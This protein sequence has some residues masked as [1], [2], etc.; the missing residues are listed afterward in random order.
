MKIIEALSWKSWKQNNQNKKKDKKLNNLVAETEASPELLKQEIAFQACLDDIDPISTGKNAGLYVRFNV[1]TIAQALLV[2]RQ[3]ILNPLQKGID[4]NY[5]PGTINTMMKIAMTEGAAVIIGHDVVTVAV[6]QE[7]KKLRDTNKDVSMVGSQERLGTV[8]TTNSM[9]HNMAKRDIEAHTAVAYD[10]EDHYSWFAM[11]V[12]V[13]AESKEIVD[14]VVTKIRSALLEGGIRCEIPRFGQL[15]TIQ[16]AMPTNVIDPN[17]LQLV[18][19][20]TISSLLPL[21]NMNATFP[22]RGPIICVEAS[23]G[24]PIKIC[25][26]KQ[27][28]ENTFILAPPGSGKTTMIFNLVSHAIGNGDEAWIIEPKNEDADGTDYINFVNAYDGSYARWGPEGIN[29]DPLIIYYNRSRMGTSIA[30][31]RK[32]KDDWFDVVQNEFRAWIGDMGERQSGLLTKSLIDLYIQREIIDGEGNPINTEKWDV[33]GALNWPSIHELRMFWNEQFEKEGTIYYHDPSIKALYM[34]TMNAEPGGSLWWLAKSKEHM[35]ISENGL[36]LFDISQLSDNMKSAVAIQIMG[37]CNSLYFPKPEDIGKRKRTYLIFDEIGKLSKTKEIV[38]YM[39]RSLREGRAPALTAVLATQDPI[40]EAEFLSMVKANCKNL[41]V[42]CNLDPMNIDTFMDAFKITDDYRNGLMQKGVG[43][44][45]YFRNRIGTRVRIELD[46]MVNEALLESK[47]G[48]VPEDP[49][50]RYGFG[51]KEAYRRLL[52]EQGFFVESWI[53]SEPMSTYPGYEYYTPQDPLYTGKLKAWILKDNIEFK[54]GLKADGTPKV[55]LVGPEGID[56]F[57]SECFICGWMRNNYFPNPEV[58]PVGL[59]DITWGEKDKDGNLIDP[60]HS[61]CIEI[62]I[63]GTHNSPSVWEDKLKRAKKMGYKHIIFTGNSTVC[64]KMQDTVI[65]AY[66]QPQGK[67][68]LL[69]ELER[70]RD[71]NIRELL[72]KSQQTPV[73]F[74]SDSGMMEA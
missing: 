36:Q 57:S 37:M 38:P 20:W 26:T 15:A 50:K 22:S 74:G 40:L 43:I 9:Y 4:I 73:E 19:Q 55:D 66:V 51:V 23:T 53:T 69:A 25:P 67:I 2:A 54:E 35:K 28:P 39:E 46:G 56:H 48:K 41:F 6:D 58:N 45:Y 13:L 31:Y 32:A 47:R 42:L 70:I 72:T 7:A 21:R 5:M 34:N 16:A 59:P 10:G 52:E 33:P 63:P 12:V 1:F 61:G 11:P 62:E 8:T 44:G 71:E 14:R 3:D 64:K 49:M 24:R 17:F 29:P 27:N 60:E 65:A 68:N 18:D 30:S